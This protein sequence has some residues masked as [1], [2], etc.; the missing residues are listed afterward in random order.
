[1]E[2]PSPSLLLILSLEEI[3]IQNISFLWCEST[4][5]SGSSNV[6]AAFYFN[7]TTKF[8]MNGC[9][10]DSCISSSSNEGDWVY[11]LAYQYEFSDCVFKNHN[12]KNP[13]GFTP[14]AES[15]S[16][17]THSITRVTIENSTVTSADGTGTWL[18]IVHGFLKST[19]S[20]QMTFDHCV[21]R[22]ISHSAVAIHDFEK[23]QAHFTFYTFEDCASDSKWYFKTPASPLS[24][25]ISDST[26]VDSKR[27][28]MAVSAT[29]SF[30]LA[31]SW[32]TFTGF[33]G[34]LTSS[35]NIVDLSGVDITE[36]GGMRFVNCVSTLILLWHSVTTSLSTAHW[37][38]EES[39]SRK[40]NQH[41][42]EASSRPPKEILT[43]WWP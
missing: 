13:I 40:A 43:A 41:S 2:E 39:W 7:G 3:T 37:V 16:K 25:E 4:G 42:I 32:N 35:N 5:A 14:A 1:M 9:V 8:T 31:F 33:K 11:S 38:A 36:L 26:F 15:L 28:M 27:D 10:I 29:T 6:G 34:S 19:S 24:S 22:R 23:M 17:V 21:F 12:R 18:G 20:K 30:E